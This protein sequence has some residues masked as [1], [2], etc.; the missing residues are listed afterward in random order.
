MRK[1]LYD[2]NVFKTRRAQLRGLLP[3]NSALL[4]AAHPQFLRNGDVHHAYRPDSNLMYLTGF[5]E[6]GAVFVFRPGQEKESILFVRPK[7][8]EMETWDGFRF[9]TELAKSEFGMDDCYSTDEMDARLGGLLNG[10]EEI[11]Y[12]FYQNDEFDGQLSEALLQVKALNRRAGVG[13]QTVHDSKPI[14]G[15]MRLIKDD[16]EIEMM[17]KA[18][19]ISAKAHVELM[20]GTHPGGN[21][22]ALHGLFLKSIMEQG[23]AREGYGSIIAGGDNA[24]TL[25]YVF[26]DCQLRDG[27][28][29]LI[30]AGAEYNYYTGDI[31]RTF[32][33][34]GK[35]TSDQ[36]RVYSNV[37]NLQKALVNSVKPGLSLAELQDR[38]VDGLVDI[39][40]E[41]KLLKGSRSEIIER[42]EHRKYYPHGIGHWLG[43]DVHDTGLMKA[44][45]KPRPFEPGMCFTIEPGIYVPRNAQGV[46]DE[47][48]G[49]GIRIE[50][51]ILVT[52][53]GHENLT[54]SAP[55]ES[56]G[57]RSAY[58]E[59][60]FILSKIFLEF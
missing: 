44:G 30:D 47:M 48:R 55:K 34:N 33:V 12:G 15:D 35:F 54:E 29:L 37:L 46:P 3:K 50:D 53:S 51:N 49:L 16:F 39:M 56:F 14:L 27:D 1:P 2:I 19:A 43:S 6:P 59:I 9:G 23:A 52:E 18:C 57:F 31:T 7:N 45:D 38:A 40:I 25:H 11:F 24:T 28:L 42:N 17:R 5:E 13:L 20:K 8:V 10:C 22:R 60:K 36:K 4:V 26:N 41:E 58:R 21:E 32:P